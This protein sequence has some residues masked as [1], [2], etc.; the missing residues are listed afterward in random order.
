MR[1]R[2]RKI[3]W[4][5]PRVY[6]AECVHDVTKCRRLWTLCLVGPVRREQTFW[7]HYE[8]TGSVSK[9]DKTTEMETTP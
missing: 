7:V 2:T 8:E 4:M 6:K 9:P 5:V 3:H 1:P